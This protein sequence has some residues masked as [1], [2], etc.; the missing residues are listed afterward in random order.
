V[1]TFRGHKMGT[2]EHREVVSFF[3]T[4]GHECWVMT[5]RVL[6]QVEAAELLFLRGVHGVRKVR[7]CEIRIVLS[8]KRNVRCANE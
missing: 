7:C 6:S 4:Y 5:E 1:V 8:D 3:L 2:F